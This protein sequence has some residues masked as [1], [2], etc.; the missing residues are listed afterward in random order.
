V[1][2]TDRLISDHRSIRKQLETLAKTA[3]QPA[4]W[5]WTRIRQRTGLLTR[6]VV[7]HAQAEE[8]LLFPLMRECPK[9]PRVDMDHYVEE[10]QAIVKYLSRLEDAVGAVGPGSRLWP[11]DFSLLEKAL[12]KHFKREE[13]QLFPLAEEFLGAERLETLSL[14]WDAQ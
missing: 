14:Q 12:E 7:T 5:D 4:P 11:Q 10:H 9:I 2:F 3:D 6:I 8:A 1:K 13:E